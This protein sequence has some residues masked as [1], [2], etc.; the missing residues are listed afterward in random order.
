VRSTAFG[1]AQSAASATHS[2]QRF[3]SSLLCGYKPHR[4]IIEC[5]HCYAKVIPS[6]DGRCPACSRNVNESTGRDP[7]LTAVIV[8]ESDKQPGTCAFCDSPTSRF[9]E[10]IKSRREKGASSPVGSALLA[11]SILFS[12]ALGLLMVLFSR[13]GRHYRLRLRMKLPQCDQCA[14]QG[15]PEPVHADFYEGELTFVVHREF[16][17]RLLELNPGPRSAA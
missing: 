10:I 6:N 16:R 3:A 5:P 1:H 11:F 13:S 12:G 14:K 7:N 15:K 4:V 2:K 8:R 9:V 17:R